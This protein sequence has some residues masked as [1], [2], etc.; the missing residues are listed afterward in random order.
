MLICVIGLDDP[1]PF[2]NRDHII[3]TEKLQN[4]ASVPQKLYCHVY[5]HDP[6]CII[7]C[8]QHSYCLSGKKPFIYVSW[9]HNSEKYM[10]LIYSWFVLQTTCA[11]DISSPLTHTSWNWRK[12]QLFLVTYCGFTLCE[13]LCNMPSAWNPPTQIDSYSQPHQELAHNK[14]AN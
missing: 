5:C 8:T 12:I 2:I 13:T 9:N 4:S 1:P 14:S 7:F 6:H 10:W 11:K 3:P